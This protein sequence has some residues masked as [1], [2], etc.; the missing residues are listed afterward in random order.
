MNEST[1]CVSCSHLY[2]AAGGMAGLAPLASPLPSRLGCVGTHFQRSSNVLVSTKAYS[3]NTHTSLTHTQ[4]RRETERAR[5]TRGGWR[6]A[7]TAAWPNLSGTASR[8]G[9]HVSP[10]SLTKMTGRSSRLPSA[11]CSDCCRRSHAFSTWS[12]PATH[13]HPARRHACAAARLGHANL[14]RSRASR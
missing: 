5:G 9:T 6:G 11:L 13:Q 14:P 1:S 3:S 2:W 4:P 8:G 10:L 7:G 12:S